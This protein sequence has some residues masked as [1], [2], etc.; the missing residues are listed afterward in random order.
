MP[1]A[2]LLADHAW[3]A[4]RRWS[5]GLMAWASF[6]AWLVHGHP[7]CVDLPAHAAQMETLAALA[8]GD[9]AV[10]AVYRWRLQLG[11]GLV[12]WLGLPLALAW[13]GAVAARALLWLALVLHPIG[14]ASLLRTLGRSLGVLP[15]LLPLSFGISY[16]YGFLPFYFTEPLLF[17]ELALF[18]RLLAGPSLARLTAVAAVGVLLALGHLLLLGVFLALAGCALLARGATWKDVARVFASLAAPL[19]LVLPRVW[20]LLQRALGPDPASGAAGGTEYAAMSHLNWFFKNYRPEGRLVALFPLAASALFCLLWLLRAGWRERA[21]RLPPALFAG[22][23]ALTAL[24]PKTLSG[25]CLVSVRLPALAAA[26]AFCLVD[27]Q[28]VPRWLRRSLL[29]LSLLSL[30]ETARFHW[31]FERALDGLDAMVAASSPHASG[32][33]STVGDQ[34]LGSKHIYLEHLGGWVTGARGGIG[35][36]FFA[37][38]DQQPIAQRS[39]GVPPSDL[40]HATPLQLSAFETV[41]IFGPP[42]FPAALADWPRLAQAGAWT[43]LGRPRSRSPAGVDRPPPGG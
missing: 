39:P 27:W 13:N 8:R 20:T 7:P 4:R 37:D 21:P 33:L 1:E 43:V 36:N 29:A 19:A 18:L 34:L 23:A 6:A 25:V 10:A 14:W 30:G 26:F 22:M 12:D 24:V 15:C 32:Y 31:R 2:P 9:A 16:W 5:L 35:Q 38:A 3:H 17:F 41:L 11:Y 40:A 42:P 28:Q